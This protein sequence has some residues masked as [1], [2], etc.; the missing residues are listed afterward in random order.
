[1]STRLQELAKQHLMMHFADMSVEP[2]DIPVLVRG[3]GSYVFDDEGRRF[4]D[5]LSGLY[6][7]NMG[8]SHGEAIG[9]RAAEQMAALPYVSNWTTAHPPSIELAAALAERAPDNINRVFFTSGG[10]E[11][12]ESAYKLALQYH[13]AMGEPERRK[14]IARR[15]AYHGS[16]LGAL[17]FTGIPGI[18]TPFEPMAVQVP[19]VSSTI[20]YRS[21]AFEQGGEAALTRSLLEEIEVAIQFER[22]ETIAMIIAEPVQNAGGSIVPPEGYWQGLREICDRYG[23][24]LVS[25]EVICAFGRLG[26]W[27][28]CQRFGY[29]PDLITVAKG[30]TGAY[31]PMGGVL[32]SDKV[33]EPFISGRNTYLHGY[34]FGG[35]PV[36]AAVAL[37]AIEVYEQERIF[38]NVLANEP[39]VREMLEGLKDIPIV[40]DVRGMGHFFAVELVRDQETREPMG[41]EE[42]EWLLND[43]LTRYLYDNGMIC[44]LDDRADPF[45]QIAPPLVAGMEEF[46]QITEILRGAL[47]VTADALEK[48]PPA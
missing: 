3:E 23:I 39:K 22:P 46:E 9:V 7:S 37:G 27:F 47:A 48:G 1:M 32:I 45:V 36:V 16:T 28:G 21:P 5:G 15:G 30:M 14:V 43:V 31:A 17:S 38:E 18:R 40:G 35:H 41:D 29:E 25:D 20:A 44:R 13:D 24:L 12:V 6:C 19:R 34:T 33:A 8:H 2:G 4:I 11:S 10:S 42:G 26:H